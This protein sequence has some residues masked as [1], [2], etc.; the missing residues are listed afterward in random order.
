M[1]KWLK[2][3]GLAA[4]VA[5]GAVIVPLYGDPRTSSVEHGEWARM[6]LRALD[7]ERSVSPCTPDTQLFSILYWKTRLAFPDPLRAKR[8]GPGPDGR[9][10]RGGGCSGGWPPAGGGEGQRLSLVRSRRN[11]ATPGPEITGFGRSTAADLRALARRRSRLGRQRPA[12]LDP[13]LHGPRSAP[14]ASLERVEVIRR[15][16]AIEPQGGCGRARGTED[17]AVTAVKALDKQSGC[18]RPGPPSKCPRPPCR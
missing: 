12:H 1:S 14:P 2:A 3:L 17:V 11:P 9:D 8:R 13:G 5:V 15:A 18:P 4:V 7:M 6:L 10:P 16:R